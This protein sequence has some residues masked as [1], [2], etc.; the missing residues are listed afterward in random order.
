MIRPG[1]QGWKVRPE[2]EPR[3]SAARF[4][5]PHHAAGGWCWLTW[6]CLQFQDKPFNVRHVNHTAW[7]GYWVSWSTLKHV[8]LYI[9]RESVGRLMYKVPLIAISQLTEVSVRLPL[10]R[11]LSLPPLSVLLQDLFWTGAVAPRQTGTAFNALCSL[12]CSAEPFLLKNLMWYTGVPR[13]IATHYIAF[14]R[15]CIFYKLK[16]EKG[17][18]SLYC[19]GQEPHLQYPRGM[20]VKSFFLYRRCEVQISYFWEVRS[21][22]S[23]PFV[24]WS[25]LVKKN[26]TFIPFSQAP[27][28]PISIDS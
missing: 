4:S 3:L 10:S 1:P 14:H 6:Q 28:W 11:L 26:R 22:V 27:S 2:F 7:I 8:Q 21:A 25:T 16:V 17:Y 24:S 12:K 20:P 13:F 9:H 5:S 19:S 23:T 18:N 15:C